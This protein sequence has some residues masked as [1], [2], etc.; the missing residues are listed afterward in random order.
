M[1]M[2]WHLVSFAR[3]IFIGKFTGR[4]LVQNMRRCYAFFRGGRDPFAAFPGRY[5]H[6]IHHVHFFKRLPFA[7]EY[8]EVDYEYGCE[9]AA[10]EHIAISEIDI[11]RDKGRK[12]PDFPLLAYYCIAW[13]YNGHAQ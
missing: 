8:K 13:V 1:L 11:S 6:H 7:L 10:G 5:A 3:L 2:C 4:S 12:E 9:K